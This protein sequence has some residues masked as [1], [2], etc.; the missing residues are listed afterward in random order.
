MKLFCTVVIFG[1]L[2]ATNVLGKPKHHKK[3]ADLPTTEDEHLKGSPPESE[4]NNNFQQLTNVATSQASPYNVPVNA[5]IQNP[6]PE[7]EGENENE[8][9]SASEKAG[10]R[11]VEPVSAFTTAMI[12]SAISTGTSLA[13]TTV[14]AMMA[15]GYSVAAAG[16]IENYSK[17]A[18]HLERNG[19]DVMGG[20]VNKPMRS[21]SPGYKEA[22]ASHKTGHSATGTQIFCPFRVN[23]K[24]RV[25]F[26]YSVPYNQDFF[27]NYLTVSICELDKSACGKMHGNDL[28]HI[29][30]EYVDVVNRYLDSLSDESRESTDIPRVAMDRHEYYRTIRSVKACLGDMCFVGEMGSSHKPTI[31][32][33]LMPAKYEGLTS[34]VKGKSHTDNWTKKQYEDY[35]THL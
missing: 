19:C 12:S 14:S 5:D 11:V 17:W 18:M 28:Y 35:V 21:I 26:M 3:K 32:M 29:R 6:I 10:K 31:S 33:R 7:D 1:L 9:E 25:M 30:L 2:L 8:V 4:D 23:G 27:S 15:P 24:Y 13:G 20:T 22:F 16:S 34:A